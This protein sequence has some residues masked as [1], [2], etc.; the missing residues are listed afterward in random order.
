[1]ELRS[2]RRK[3][4]CATVK[5]SSPYPATIV[6]RRVGRRLRRDRCRLSGV[7]RVVD[8]SR[9]VLKTTR[10]TRHNCPMKI[11]IPKDQEQ[12][13]QTRV[14]DGDF[15]S[16]EEGVR[17]VIADRMALEVDDLAWARPAVEL[18]R[19]AAARGE[20]MSLEEALADM[21]AHLATLER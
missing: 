20:V 7:A 15:T 5:A 18:A 21:R 1:M 13:L 2:R 8:M 10:E 6:Q 19:A 14:A 3:I 12:W 4:Q 16:V 17:R 11:D 9:P